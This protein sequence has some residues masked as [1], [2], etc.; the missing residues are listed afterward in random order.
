MNSLR[1]QQQAADPKI[2]C[3]VAASAGSGKTKVLID[4]LVN[5]LLQGVQPERILCLTFTRAAAAEMMQRLN[6]RLQVL[7]ILDTEEAAAFMAAQDFSCLK[8]PRALFLEV[9]ETFPKIQTIHSFCQNLLQQFP[10]EAGISSHFR[11]LSE[12]ERIGLIDQCI[13]QIFRQAP[14]A[15]SYWSEQRF[16]ELARACLMQTEMIASLQRPLENDFAQLLH[17]P[18]DWQDPVSEVHLMQIFSQQQVIACEDV[19][20]YCAQYLTQNGEIRKAQLKSPEASLIAEAVKAFHDKRM[21]LRVAQKT[22]DFLGIMRPIAVAYQTRKHY[23]QAFDF[24]DLI[25]LSLVLLQAA[26]MAPWILYKLAGGIEHLLI[27]EAQD[28]SREQWQ[29][30]QLLAN[31]LLS[32]EARTLFAVGD[33]KQ[34]IY[35]FQGAD[36]QHFLELRQYFQEK[37]QH[38]GGL[39]RD[40]ALDVS[41]RTAPEI[42]Y[43]VDTYFQENPRG[44]SFMAE[45]LTHQAFRTT[46]KG[47]IVFWPLVKAMSSVLPESWGLP[48]SEENQ[49]DPQRQAAESIATRVRHL[50]TQQVIEPGDILILVRRRS[51]FVDYVIQAL[52]RWQIPVAGAD[53]LV[54]TDHLAIQDLIAFGQFL[55]LPEDDFNLA[56][57]LKS[58]LV[59]CDEERLFSLCYQRPGSLWQQLQEDPQWLAI[60]Q[61]LKAWLIQAP[62]LTPYQL[63]STLLAKDGRPKI[64][65]RFGSEVGEVLDEFLA[66]ALTYGDSHT[67]SLQTFLHFLQSVP[68]TLQRQVVPD[69]T[70]RVMTVHGSKGLEAPVVIIVDS[71]DVHTATL[72]PFLLYDNKETRGFLLRPRSEEDCTLTKSLKKRQE[73]HAWEEENRL[74]YVAMTRAK[75]RLYL[76]GWENQRGKASWYHDLVAALNPSIVQEELTEMMALEQQ[77]QG[78]IPQWLNSL[79]TVVSTQKT[80]ATFV[81]TAVSTAASERG[82]RIHRLLEVLP[83][84]PVPLHSKTAERILGD[85]P[86]AAAIF[87]QVQAI[88]ANPAWAPFFGPDS[89][90]E[91]PII[92]QVNGR[93]QNLRIDRLLIQPERIAFLDYK[94]HAVPPMTAAAIPAAMGEQLAFYAW[95]LRKLYPQRQQEIYILW[96]E[97]LTLMP[98]PFEII[99][100]HFARWV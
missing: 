36:P 95:H 49:A 88:L 46:V 94:T 25:S 64:F 31:D 61:W 79:P 90:A 27:D 65:Q 28:T 47:Q 44:V 39:W 78:L 23:L 16:R 71:P 41:F 86:D 33:P 24:S 98:V 53:R 70:V 57:L 96:T 7:A 91:V 75:D 22:R 60:V 10:L 9:L 82:T 74:L 43:S 92:S 56:C 45:K 80:S 73:Q 21:A 32:C 20:A 62:F 69:N 59:G 68:P 4:R 1:A 15:F 55:L 50:L 93:T 12:D 5:L 51:P 72:N 100:S 40:I 14:P 17:L 76:T 89:L 63:Y 48:T 2:S 29:F 3:W 67:A 19:D 97:T 83:T 87:D 26:D 8:D 37:I 99:E 35:G 52:K 38:G 42:L 84:L 54:L 66:L 18:G 81:S 34:S 85:L 58:P 13:D 30:I 77:T 11:I 6:Q